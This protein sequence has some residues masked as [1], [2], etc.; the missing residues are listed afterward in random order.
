M[1][2]RSQAVIVWRR[3]L[4][5]AGKG[6]QG[7]MR[8]FAADEG[9]SKRG[10]FIAPLFPAEPCWGVPRGLRSPLGL[11]CDDKMVRLCRFLRG[12]PQATKER[13]E[14]RGMRR[15]EPE[16]AEPFLRGRG[17]FVRPPLGS[18]GTAFAFF[19]ANAVT[20]RNDCS[21]AAGQRRHSF[22]IC[23]RKNCD[24]A[25][26]LVRPPLGSDGTAFA[27]FFANAVT[28]RNDLCGYFPWGC[29]WLCLR[30]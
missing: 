8:T 19:F 1:F 17:L 28:E 4:G 23:F 6:G 11:R 27:F 29:V 26:R 16:R 12:S 10:L 20:E 7:T 15:P 2:W 3:F 25:G 30:R 14:E 18:D 13:P 21:T 24:G 5:D 9:G 22:C